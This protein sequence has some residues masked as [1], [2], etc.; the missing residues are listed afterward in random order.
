MAKTKYSQGL[1]VPQNPAKYCGPNLKNIRF[2]SGWESAVMRHFD[3]HPYV[4]SWSSEC[5]S[6]PYLHPLLNKKKMYIPDFFVVWID[7]KGKQ[8]AEI[9][10]IKPNKENPFSNKKGNISY[11]TRLIQA[12]NYAKWAAA[13]AYCAKRGIKFRVVTEVELFAYTKK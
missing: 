9:W 10:E 8:F 4:I 5:I 13:V 7:K 3:S 11:Q 2:R 1:F 6:I 12:I